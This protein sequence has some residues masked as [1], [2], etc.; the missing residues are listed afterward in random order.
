MAS[1]YAPRPAALPTKAAD[2]STPYLAKADSGSDARRTSPRK[3]PRMN[4]RI[5]DLRKVTERLLTHLEEIGRGE[6]S[7]SLDYYW[8]IPRE[9]RYDNY[10][11]PSDLSLHQLTDD[12]AELQKVLDGKTAPRAEALVRL[13]S[14]LRAVGEEVVD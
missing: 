9:L 10:E 8:D 11:Q 4:L 1:G 6:V 2:L 12:W 5:S 3:K 13:S 7:L 14:L